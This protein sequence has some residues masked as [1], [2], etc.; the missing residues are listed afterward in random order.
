[1]SGQIFANRVLCG[2][3]VA[4]GFVYKDSAFPPA[5]QSIGAVKSGGKNEIEWR[6]CATMCGQGGSLHL[7]HDDIDPSDIRQGSLGDCW[8]L[9]AFACLAN[10]PGAIQRVFR[11]KTAN[12]R[13]KYTCKIFCRPKNKWVRISIDDKIPCS[14]ST[15][16]PL[17]AQPCG[18]EAWVM[19][20]EKVFAKYCGSYAAL[21]GGDTLWA[22][23]ALTGDHVY[24]F[25]RDK[26]DRQWKKWKL[27]HTPEKGPRSSHLT[28]SS[29][30]KPVPDARF[31]ALL[32]EH[33]RNGSVLECSMGA[34]SDSENSD[35]IVHGHAY[36][37]LRIVEHRGVQ[38]VQ[39][40]NPWG[41]FEWTGMW[42]DTS[43]SWSKSPKVAKMCH[44]GEEPA[45]DGK[46]WMSWADFLRYF[47]SVGLC[48]RTTGFQDLSLDSNEE[49]G[50]CGALTGCMAGCFRFWCCCQGV[51]ALCCAQ[52]TH[53]EL[54]M[55]GKV[56]AG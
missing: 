56:A 24:K 28:S 39:L 41:N 42:S 21:E 14:G 12:S 26:A 31:F 20:L 43:D 11:N 25:T 40:R 2:L 34:G 13:G 6:S 47:S 44:R 54:Y 55:S 22:L 1:V 51:K 46:F 38:L 18:D 33:C 53:E 29:A 10:Y 36:S 19:L 9:S 30:E 32:K 37:L 4:C 8:L 52:A 49:K 16:K 23:E 5:P 48:Y 35:G 7:F 45:N 50:C 15:G 17:F 3:C 27:V